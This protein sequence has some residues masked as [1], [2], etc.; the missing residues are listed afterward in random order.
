MSDLKIFEAR[1]GCQKEIEEAVR[2]Y[3]D[4]HAGMVVKDFQLAV[5]QY[6]IYLAVLF[7]QGYIDVPMFIEKSR[8]PIPTT[9]PQ[10]TCQD[11]PWKG[12]FIPVGD[13][14][15]RNN[16]VP[17]ARRANPAEQFGAGVC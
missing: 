9:L 12:E 14:P 2:K 1:P 6:S 11:D 17:F 4:D 10:I 5:S 8:D 16:V 15:R 13:P 7:T 3:L